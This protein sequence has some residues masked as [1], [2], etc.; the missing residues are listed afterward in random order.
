MNPTIRFYV[1][2]KN[3]EPNIGKCLDALRAADVPVTVF[4]SGS[5]DGTL[6]VLDQAGIE[7]THYRYV[8]HCSAYNEITTLSGEEYCGIL[9]AD[10][11]I[12]SALVTEIRL[13]LKSS[14]VV[15]TPI[16]MY[17][18]GIPLRRGSLYPPKAIAFRRGRRYFEPV[19]HGERLMDDV[20]AATT[21][22][23]LVHNDLKPFSAYVGSQVRY[24]EKFAN[25]AA[26]GERNWRDW[27]RFHTPLMMFITP[28]YSLFVKGGAWSRAGWLYAIDR[29]IAEAMMYR[30]SLALGLKKPVR[31]RHEEN[32]AKT[33]TQD[34]RP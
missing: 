31:A 15:K 4:D 33:A 28:A 17:V 26:Q 22:H 14:D 24:S 30:R 6:A 27:L 11:E 34:R 12:S 10:M 21:R 25:R 5:T 7:V 8:D 16:A 9:D 3:E 19:G 20:Q 13:L 2:C 23:A 32:P 29:L 18:D 1:L